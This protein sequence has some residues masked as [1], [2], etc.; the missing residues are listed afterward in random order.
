[1]A[2]SYYDEVDSEK[3]ENKQKMEELIEDAKWQ[4]YA[5][6]WQ[7]AENSLNEALKNAVNLRDKTKID[8]ILSLLEKCRRK[9]KVELI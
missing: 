4:I 6:M 8:E 7:P 1:M 9:E 3:E 5:E 2:K